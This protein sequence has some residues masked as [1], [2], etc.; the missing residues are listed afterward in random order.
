MKVE[1]IFESWHVPD[2]NYPPLSVGD[3][4]NLS[5]EFQH[6]TLEASNHAHPYFKLLYN[7]EY[8][9]CGSVL[10]KYKSDEE[11][12]LVI[13]AADFRFYINSSTADVMSYAAGDKLKGQGTLLLD[14]YIWVEFL[15]SYEDP[16]ELFYNL[17][18]K[19]IRRM[20]I[21]QKFIHKHLLGKSQPTRLNISELDSEYI[22]ELETML[23]QSFDEEFYLIEF[24][25]EGLEN[26]EIPRTFIT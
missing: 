24:D 17:Q 2:G 20:Q 22:Q 14:H 3:R 8:E 4:V 11:T 16:P 12:I 10:R 19:R 21:P 9:F 7:A 26:R 6:K 1:A 5:F 15:D 23:G 13:E 25:T 18:V